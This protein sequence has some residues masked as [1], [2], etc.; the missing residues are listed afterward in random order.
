MRTNQ[1]DVNDINYGGR[2]VISIYFILVSIFGFIGNLIIL[3]VL[4]KIPKMR[5]HTNI[6]IGS[7]AVS[8]ISTC[9]IIP[10]LP[11]GILSMTGWP[12]PNW[13]CI[14]TSILRFVSQAS[15]VWNLVIIAINRL[16]L[17]TMSTRL[18]R[19]L[20]QPWTI[21]INIAFVWLFPFA[22]V[23]IPY[24][25]GAIDIGF[26]SGPNICS[27]TDLDRYGNPTKTFLL[28]QGLVLS[29]FPL[30]LVFISYLRIYIFVRSHIRR[31][32][33]TNPS[34]ISAPKTMRRLTPPEPSSSLS[35]PKGEYG[36][37]SRLQKQKV[38]MISVIKGL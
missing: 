22:T 2:I 8:D 31:Q 30:C 37:N 32:E 14:V 25:T 36:T 34:P 15:S 19:K 6:F 28:I 4:F 33:K 16:V 1:T 17:V 13:I 20:Y 23:I 27:D 3:I 7:L 18:Y 29:C 26:D 9:L 10:F 11:A 38:C 35:D 5:T 21:A 24:I 12:L